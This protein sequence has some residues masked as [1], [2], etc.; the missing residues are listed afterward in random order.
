MEW[1]I[2]IATGLISGLITGFITGT[3]VAGYFRHKDQ[4][5]S[6]LRYA[7]QT[8]D[9]AH[10][11]TI[12][13]KE[14]LSGKEPSHLMELLRRPIHRGF[15]IDIPDKKLQ[16]TISECNQGLQAIKTALD[17]DNRHQLVVAHGHMSGKLVDLWNATTEYERCERSKDEKERKRFRFC[18]MLAIV[19]PV[20][21]IVLLLVK[22]Y[23]CN[24]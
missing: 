3:L 18:F 9:H 2:G 13:A 6:V 4:I 23:L 16:E 17:Q 14:Y 20:A 15:V 10:G 8:A 7:T 21:L 19:F 24:G 5:R 11:I 22:R 12:E 1:V